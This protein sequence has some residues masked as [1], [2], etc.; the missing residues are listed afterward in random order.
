LITTRNGKHT[1][2][3]QALACFLS[4]IEHQDVVGCRILHNEFPGKHPPLVDEKDF[5]HLSGGYGSVYGR[6][7]RSISMLAAANTVL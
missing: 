6:G 2:S 5:I 1:C 7:N 3:T 4:E